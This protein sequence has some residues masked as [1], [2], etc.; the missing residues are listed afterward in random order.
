MPLQCSRLK[1]LT[2]T[3]S[4]GSSE[5]KE[6]EAMSLMCPMLMT[7]SRYRLTL[8]KLNYWSCLRTGAT[9]IQVFFL[10]SLLKFSTNSTTKDWGLS[11]AAPPREPEGIGNWRRASAFCWGFQ[12]RSQEHIYSYVPKS[13]R[14]ILTCYF[15]V[16][17][18]IWC[19]WQMVSV[20]GGKWGPFLSDS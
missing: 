11:K 3:T 12:Y 10:P 8:R 14:I 1:K 17:I 4:S 5:T 2:S 13:D 9:T 6:T 15:P 16:K 19:K 7:L 18:Y 20:E